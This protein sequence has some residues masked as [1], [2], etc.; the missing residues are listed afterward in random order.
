[1]KF[2]SILFICFVCQLSMAQ[3]KITLEACESALQKSNLLLLAEQFNIEASKAAVIQAKIWDLP[4]VSGEFNLINPQDGRVLDVGGRGQKVVA[5]QQLIYLGGKKKNQIEF[6]KSNIAI[7]ELQFEQLL[8]NLRYQ[9]HQSYY[10]VY[11]DQNKINTFDQQISHVDTLLRAYDAQAKKGNLPLKDVVRLQNLLI[12][13]RSDRT[14]FQKGI[15]E[16]QQILSTITGIS[17]PIMPQANEAELVNK[18]RIAKIKNDAMLD[19]AIEKNPEYLTAIKIIE[20]QELMLKWQNSLVKPDLTAGLGYDQRGGAFSNQV[21][22]TFAI[23]VSLWN[24][25]KGNIKIAENQLGQAKINKDFKVLELKS[26]ID[27]AYRQWQ[28]QQGY[29]DSF[30]QNINQNLE[31]VYMG[32]LQN[33]QKSNISILEFT[34]FMESYN[35]SSVELN[36][37]KKQLILSGENLNYI[38]NSTIF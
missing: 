34:D 36:E 6:A 33:F 2:L 13:L 25:N 17:S 29:F 1:M 7:A 10:K 35:Q 32:V 27:G 8:R 14:E 26:Q 22:F 24:R 3:Q 9:L 11:F 38:V 18:Y 21:N 15:I 4:V 20:S 30:T 31:A 16:Q 19:I 23:P 12:A 37:A 28:T 5:V